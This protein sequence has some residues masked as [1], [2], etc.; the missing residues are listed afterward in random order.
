MWVETDPKLRQYS[1]LIQSVTKV[2]V[3]WMDLRL[4]NGGFLGSASTFKPIILTEIS[5]VSAVS[6]G[7]F[8]EI[9]S[10]WE[11]EEGLLLIK[12]F[13]INYPPV[14]LTGCAT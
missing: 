6:P 9:T 7:K 3:V 10:N 4:R 5:R 13:K 8:R 12:Q 14:T 11:K 2:E 1:L